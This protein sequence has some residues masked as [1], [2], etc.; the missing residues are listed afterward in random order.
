MLNPGNLAWDKQLCSPFLSPSSTL[1]NKGSLT[2]VLTCWFLYHVWRC[3]YERALFPALMSTSVEQWT[4]TPSLWNHP[5]L[6]E[7]FCHRWTLV[8]P[9]YKAW[10]RCRSLIFG[11]LKLQHSQSFPHSLIH[12]HTLNMSTLSGGHESSEWQKEKQK[13]NQ[14]QLKN[15]VYVFLPVVISLS[16]HLADSISLLIMWRGFVSIMDEGQSSLHT[17]VCAVSYWTDM[18]KKSFLVL[19]ID[20]W[21]FRYDGSSLKSSD[22]KRWPVM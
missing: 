17:Q 22:S 4:G 20:D 6:V 13:S 11:T 7:R 14:P 19:H 12:T 15:M 3:M 10:R 16:T 1:F 21:V 9:K 8:E 18:K 5:W 2:V